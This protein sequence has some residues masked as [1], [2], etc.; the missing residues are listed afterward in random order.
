LRSSGIKLENYKKRFG[1][2]WLKKNNSYF[3]ELLKKDLI[4]FDDE[5]LKLT[6][7]GYTLCDEILKNIL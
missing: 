2:D 4:L 1:N 5:I 6:A 3:E 7:K